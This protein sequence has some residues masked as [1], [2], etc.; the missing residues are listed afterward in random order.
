[1]LQ[2]QDVATHVPIPAIQVVVLLVAMDAVVPAKE[3]VVDV[4]A[5]VEV[6]VLVMHFINRK[7]SNY[8]ESIFIFYIFIC[9]PIFFVCSIQHFR[10]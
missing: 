7:I 9:K 10:R 2:K 1:M 3:V 6:V 4:K 5:F 8:E